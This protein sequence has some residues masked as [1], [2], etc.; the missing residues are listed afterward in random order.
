MTSEEMRKKMQLNEKELKELLKELGAF[1][2]KLNEHQRA[3][4]DQSLPKFAAAAK[5]FGPDVTAE[6]LKKLLDAEGP[7][8]FAAGAVVAHLGLNP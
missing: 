3:V 8:G 2:A 7:G 5:T 4:L 6:E 1:L